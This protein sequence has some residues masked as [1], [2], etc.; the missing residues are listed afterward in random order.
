LKEIDKREPHESRTDARE[1]ERHS[2]D[3]YRE[4]EADAAR[5]RRGD[6]DDRSSGSTR[7]E[8]AKEAKVANDKEAFSNPERPK[9]AEE[10]EEDRRKR[11]EER[12]RERERE[13]ELE[14]EDAAQEDPRLTRSRLR[15]SMS[16]ER[17]RQLQRRGKQL[18]MSRLRK[19]GEGAREYEA[20]LATLMDPELHIMNQVFVSRLPKRMTGDEVIRFFS[21]KVGPV[22]RVYKKPPFAQG[23][24]TF[25]NQADV[26]R[27]IRLMDGFRY[28][29]EGLGVTFSSRVL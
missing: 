16:P 3:R 25:E 2:R 26:P 13:R 20:R 19:E 28:H 14:L 9:S 17:L 15:D 22:K 7:K 12:L 27:A 11:R 18:Q 5:D 24:V 21:D 10:R 1:S 8:D 29:G 6:I 4:R 23:W